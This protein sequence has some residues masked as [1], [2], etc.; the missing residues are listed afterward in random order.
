MTYQ[1]CHLYIFIALL[2][3]STKASLQVV[4][5]G[6]ILLAAT[7]AGP[8]LSSI[9]KGLHILFKY[10]MEILRADKYIMSTF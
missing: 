10:F 8:V 5:I 6:E 2:A 3:S 4:K 7:I 9:G 1:Y